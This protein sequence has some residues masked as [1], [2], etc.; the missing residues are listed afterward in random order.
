MNYCREIADY[1]SGDEMNLIHCA[2]PCIYQS[3]GYCGM[4]EIGRITNAEGGCPHYVSKDGNDGFT[5][6]SHGM[7]GD[8][9]I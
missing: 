3:E 9:E 2:K 4:D 8:S 7:E 6:I 5:E 1:I